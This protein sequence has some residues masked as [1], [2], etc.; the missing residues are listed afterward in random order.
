VLLAALPLPFRETS[1]AGRARAA[2]PAVLALVATVSQVQESRGS[3][4]NE[5]VHIGKAISAGRGRP[6]SVADRDGVYRQMQGAIPPGAPLLVMLDEPFWLDFRRN[7]ISLVDL[8]GA[9]SPPPGMPL[10]DDQALVDYLVARGFHYLA[11]VRPSAS[12]SLYKRDTWARLANESQEPIW[13]L[14]APFYLHMF[15]RVESLEKSRAHLFDDGRMVALDL[16]RPRPKEPAKDPAKVPAKDL[17]K[18]PAKDSA[19][20]PAKDPAKTAAPKP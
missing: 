7:P 14:E 17:A 4:F 11:F 3:T 15:D 6:S 16:D 1:V 12:A 10:D 18:V 20:E 13:K 8:P 2:V 9:V 19:K 5:Y